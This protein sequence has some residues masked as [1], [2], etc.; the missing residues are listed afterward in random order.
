MLAEDTNV[1]LFVGA[2]A[3]CTHFRFFVFDAD[4]LVRE[5]TDATPICFVAFDRF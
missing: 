1:A 5:I 3:N 4:I 2:D